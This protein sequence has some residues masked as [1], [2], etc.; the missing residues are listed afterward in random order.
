[1]GKWDVCG[2]GKKWDVCGE[3]HS[4]GNEVHSAGKEGL[5]FIKILNSNHDYK[6]FKNKEYF[7]FKSINL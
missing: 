7:I 4:A 6:T 2:E 3:V 5:Y 1:M